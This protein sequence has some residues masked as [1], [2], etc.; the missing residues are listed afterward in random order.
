M[1]LYVFVAFQPRILHRLDARC[2]RRKFGSQRSRLGRCQ[3]KA[4]IGALP[5]DDADRGG[6]MRPTLGAVTKCEPDLMR[7]IAA[8]P[9]AQPNASVT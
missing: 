2:V 9:G 8:M 3:L 1:I 4:N 7:R 6:F 5:G